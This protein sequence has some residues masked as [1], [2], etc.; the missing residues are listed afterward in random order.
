MIWRGFLFDVK[1]FYYIQDG[2]LQN[3]HFLTNNSDFSLPLIGEVTWSD[4]PDDSSLVAVKMLKQD[5]S[6]ETQEDF[7]RK[8][9][10]M[11]CR[12]VISP[13][14]VFLYIAKVT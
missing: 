11:C 7:V 9:K 4:N 12:T 3:C 2:L 8:V 10:T 13:L 5:A 6:R 1:S 14:L